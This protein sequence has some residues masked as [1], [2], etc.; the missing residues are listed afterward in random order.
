MNRHERRSG[1]ARFRRNAASALLTY[2]VEPDDAA[3]DGHP[4]LRQAA[5]YW[6]SNIRARRPCCIGCR[7]SFAAD[8]EPGAF[9]FAVP[10]LARTASISVFCI[11]CWR[12]LPEA[13]IE[14][15]CARV[16]QNFAPGGH[17]LD[18]GRR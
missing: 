15:V 13:D 6:R 8:A 17:F 4:L 3:L 2:L 7:T 14:R 18:A 16:L 9:L 10:A 12:D 11:R 1:L 5:S